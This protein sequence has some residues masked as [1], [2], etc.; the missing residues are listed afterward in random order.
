MNTVLII[1]KIL[2]S[3]TSCVFYVLAAVVKLPEKPKKGDF[4][5]A[6]V[7]EDLWKALTKTANLNKLGGF[8]LSLAIIIEIVEIIIE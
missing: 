6:K 2:F 5:K 8:I 3:V 1:I 4:I 7:F